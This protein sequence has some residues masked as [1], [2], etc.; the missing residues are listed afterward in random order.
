MLNSHLRKLSIRP[1]WRIHFCSN[2]WGWKEDL[3]GYRSEKFQTVMIQNFGDTAESFSDISAK[4]IG[5]LGLL[6]WEIPTTIFRKGVHWIAH[7][8]E[9]HIYI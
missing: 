8:E 9:A 3:L 1:T 7:L 5:K 4:E 2:L 6:F